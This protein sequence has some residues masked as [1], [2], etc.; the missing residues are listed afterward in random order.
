M[1]HILLYFLITFPWISSLS[2]QT[3][4]LLWKVTSPDG[5]H[6]SFLLGASNEP[7]TRGM[8]APKGIEEL[9][10]SCEILYTAEDVFLQGIINKAYATH[11]SF[12]E[13]SERIETLPDFDRLIRSFSNRFHV[14]PRDYFRDREMLTLVGRSGRS[15]VSNTPP[16]YSQLATY[17]LKQAIPVQGIDQALLNEPRIDIPEEVWSEYFSAIINEGNHRQQNSR[18][19]SA[20]RS[21]DLEYFTS[22]KANA[23][24]LDYYL[25]TN[26][27]KQEFQDQTSRLSKALI[28]LLDESSAFVVL[29][30]EHLPGQEGVLNVLEE[31]GFVL[32]PVINSTVPLQLFLEA[33]AQEPEWQ[34][35]QVKD[36][37][38][39]LEL[40]GEVSTA[41]GITKIAPDLAFTLHHMEMPP[42]TGASFTILRIPK[43]AIPEEYHLENLQILGQE[44]PRRIGDRLY[45]KKL[46]SI[47]EESG[48]SR[49]VLQFSGFN[50]NTAVLE[51]S[52][53]ELGVNN[54]SPTRFQQNRPKEIVRS[55]YTKFEYIILYAQGLLSPEELNMAQRIFES[56]EFIP[57]EEEKLPY[58]ASDRG[59]EI[60]LP[61]NGIPM[62]MTIPIPGT[63]EKMDVKLLSCLRAEDKPVLTIGS[64]MIGENRVFHDDE[65]EMARY[66]QEIENQPL[67]QEATHKKIR[68]QFTDSCALAE[69]S[70]IAPAGYGLQKGTRVNITYMIRGAR[71][72]S[73]TSFDENLGEGPLL[74]ECRQSFSFTPF[75]APPLSLY[76]DTENRYELLLPS[77][78][79]YFPRDVELSELDDLLI[80]RNDMYTAQDTFSGNTVGVLSVEYNKYFQFDIARFDSLGVGLFQQLWSVENPPFE[81]LQSSSF[82]RNGLTYYEYLIHPEKTHNHVR[83]LSILNGEWIHSL[84]TIG[85]KSY[86]ASPW[87]DEVFLSFQPKNIQES[88]I[89]KD[90]S[91]L[92]IQTINTGTDQEILESLAVL[93]TCYLPEESTDNYYRFLRDDPPF[94]HPNQNI[95]IPLLLESIA[96][97]KPDSVE[98]LAKSLFDKTF[99]AELQII[100]L[101]TLSQLTFPGYS[102]VFAYG[103]QHTNWDMFGDALPPLYRFLEISMDTITGPLVWE[104]VPEL[105][106]KDFWSLPIATYLPA[107]KELG[108]VSD[109]VASTINDHMRELAVTLWKK[110]K[111]HP[112]PASAKADDELTLATCLN[113]LSIEEPDKNLLKLFKKIRKAETGSFLESQILYNQIAWD[114][115]LDEDLLIEYVESL[116]Y[117]KKLL[118][119]LNS[120]NSLS[121]LPDHLHSAYSRAEADIYVILTDGYVEADLHLFK[122]LTSWKDEHGYRYVFEAKI[123]EDDP[124]SYI[125]SP[126]FTEESFHP[127]YPPDSYSSFQPDEEVDLKDLEKIFKELAE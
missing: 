57:I 73:I 11:P 74:E 64:G 31:S 22:W 107:A 8:I 118:S 58:H 46:S 5:Q 51:E 47:S 97:W 86:L 43:P 35:I 76:A 98:K 115:P 79:S 104:Y 37:P 60:L 20:L 12:W 110:I 26:R 83:I 78:L 39:S 36:L 62:S 125:I 120:T 112:G 122:F 49:P 27:L 91:D 88:V 38:F 32:I 124:V 9:I 69:T 102:E 52:F 17:A 101:E 77:K 84:Y 61:Y 40:P 2:A 99:D 106:D 56:L 114:L 89:L 81:V 68:T 18:Y 92:I 44:V 96:Y 59:F 123:L 85:P 10:T 66:R 113:A 108:I 42:F 90:K 67:F 82:Q 63:S 75:P 41:R 105:L 48:Y 13:E 109:E 30:P 80:R 95:I 23:S 50:F 71:N 94:T 28:R 15:Y 55:F 53:Q 72:Y 14:N 111:D 16:Y 116:V 126:A 103:L 45:P 33:G 93:Q 24:D 127:N 25:R 54:F 6:T 19:Y 3:S 65:E 7:D 87:I 34:K 121:Q 4:S 100:L 119:I 29:Q 70:F 117:R 1:K 21:G